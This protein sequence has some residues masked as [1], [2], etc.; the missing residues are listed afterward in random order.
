M[1]AT[2]NMNGARDGGKRAMFYELAKQKRADVFFL[3][4]TH[5]DGDNAVDWS[6]E[7]EGLVILSHNSTVSG[8]FG[9][10]FSNNFIP[11]S[12][13]V[14]EI[15]PGRL[16]KVQA[17]YEN[18]SFVFICVYAPTVAVERM[19]FLDRLSSLI[20]DCDFTDFLVL[21]GDFNCAA[22]TLDR[23][24]LEPHTASRR[25]LCELLEAHDLCDIW[26]TL[27]GNQRQYTWTH[28]RDNA[29]SLARL[30]RFYSF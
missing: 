3:Q 10:L 14:D 12:Y 25:R 2:L 4:E 13:T 7:W 16:L 6:K 27:H 29:L 20:S 21:G 8:G 17:C 23:N 1:I 22:D 19:V 26:R 24:H 9:V 28:C 15:L 5:S 18:E 11:H 30:D